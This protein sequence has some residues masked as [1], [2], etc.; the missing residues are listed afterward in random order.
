MPVGGC[1]P[2]T[3][4]PAQIRRKN[5]TVSMAYKIAVAVNKS[6][7][8]GVALNAVAHASLGLA[9]KASRD[10][11]EVFTG[12]DFQNYADADGG[13]HDFILARSLIVL[14]GRN[15]EL[16]RLRE[17]ARREGLVS[18]DF[19]HQMTGDTFVEQLVRSAATPSAEFQ[20]YA[21]AVAGPVDELDPL[22]RK[23][24]LWR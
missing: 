15:G 3:K 12:F 13:D 23:L 19:T 9:A 11:A 6:L 4:N 16:R 10:H 7:E 8:P 20:Y 21:V 14:R 22:T 17:D 2:A 24:S 5:G 1:D 18:V